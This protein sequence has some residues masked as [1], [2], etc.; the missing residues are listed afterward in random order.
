MLKMRGR[1]MW[2]FRNGIPTPQVPRD[3]LVNDTDEIQREIEATDR[4]RL[5]VGPGKH[6]LRRVQLVRL[7]LLAIVDESAR[8]L[9]ELQTES[10]MR[11]PEQKLA[12]LPC[13]RVLRSQ[14]VEE[15]FEALLLEIG[16]PK[17]L[18]EEK[19]L[20]TLASASYTESKPSMSYPGL[21]TEYLVHEQTM[22]VRSQAV[23]R[24]D[25]IGLPQGQA[26]EK[27]LPVSPLNCVTRQFFWPVGAPAP[28][29]PRSCC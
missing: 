25:T 1:Q 23:H 24:A 20:V 11:A 14:S 15:A 22:K 27:E 13:R 12:K 3:V 8:A 7:R 28:K 26:F 6:L 16:V 19:L 4:K 2:N 5:V 21:D 29:N 9:V 18:I 10:W 17:E